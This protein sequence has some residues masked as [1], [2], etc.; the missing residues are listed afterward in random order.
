MLI[1]HE[2]PNIIA[3]HYQKYKKSLRIL[4]ILIDVMVKKEPTH[5]PCAKV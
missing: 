3:K 4:K 5:C 2:Y 1:L